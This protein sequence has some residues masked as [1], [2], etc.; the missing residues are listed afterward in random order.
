MLFPVDDGSWENPLIED[1]KYWSQ[2]MKD[3]LGFYQDG[4]FP[5]Q[6]TP[7][8]QTKIQKPIPA[9]DFCEDL[10]YI[11]RI[12]YHQVQRNLQEDTDQI[13]NCKIRKKVAQR[14][15]PELLATAAKLCSVVRNNRLWNF[16][17]YTVPLRLY[18]KP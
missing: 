8:I 17:R 10:R 9:V 1:G 16:S 7:F 2:A 15:G 14:A 4:G 12:L 13:H 5:S 3:A 11:D 6:L 18:S